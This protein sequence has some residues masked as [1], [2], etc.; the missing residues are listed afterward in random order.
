MEIPKEQID[1]VVAILQ[2]GGVIICPTE[3]VY[4]LIAAADNEAAI[5]RIYQIKGRDDHQPMQVLVPSLEVAENLAKFSPEACTVA[6]AFWPGALTIIVPRRDEAAIAER[7]S[8]GTG[9]LGL[10]RSAHPMVQAILE[11]AGIPLAASSANL[12]GE[13]NPVRFDGI[14][15]EVSGQVDSVIDGGACNVGMASTVVDMSGELKIL[16]EGKI[17]KNQ[18]LDALNT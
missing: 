4:G 17:S 14:S 13:P 18:L 7:P 5:A 12:A 6:K 9:T 11:Q 16:R 1:E 10:R 15:T 2:G 3:T 8:A